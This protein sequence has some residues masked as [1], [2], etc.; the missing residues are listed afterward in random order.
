MLEVLIMEPNVQCANSSSIFPA[1]VITASLYA[2]TLESGNIPENPPLAIT[3]DAYSSS[4]SHS[5][6]F[7]LDR[8]A[9]TNT[10]DVQKTEAWARW[11]LVVASTFLAR[12]LQCP[13]QTVKPAV[14][15]GFF[16]FFFSFQHITNND[17]ALLNRRFWS[18]EKMKRTGP[19]SLRVAWDLYS[20]ID[21]A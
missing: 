2:L 17:S 12:K 18:S 1:P 15:L 7:P 10:T 21:L 8:R 5:L 20:E 4:V 16:F 19:F 11:S 3:K 14:F 6:P 13:Q 9:E